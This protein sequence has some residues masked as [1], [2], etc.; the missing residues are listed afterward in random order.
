MKLAKV[1]AAILLARW[2]QQL[3]VGTLNAGDGLA[4]DGLFYV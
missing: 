3:T 4:G 2:G 1:W